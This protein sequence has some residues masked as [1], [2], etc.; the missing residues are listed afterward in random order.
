MREPRGTCFHDRSP[1]TLARGVMNGDPAFGSPDRKRRLAARSLYTEAFH[2]WVKKARE[3]IGSAEVDALA[4]EVETHLQDLQVAE[5]ELRVQTEELEAALA[6]AERQR[7]RYRE[8]F[9]NAPIPYLTTDPAGRILEANL[10]AAA[11]LGLEPDRARGQPLHVFLADGSQL[12]IRILGVTAGRPVQPWESEVISGSGSAIPVEISV[13]SVEPRRGDGLE[14]LWMLHDVRSRRQARTREGE[15]HREQAARAALKQV[16]LRARFLADASGRLMGVLEPTRVWEVAAELAGGHATAALLVESRGEN[17]VCVRGIGGAGG[18]RGRLESLMGRVVE[19]GDGSVEG[20]PLRPIRV[21]LERGEPEIIPSPE[22]PPESAGS[23]LVVPVRSSSRPWGAMVLWLP[24]E[25]RI[26]EE[27]LVADNLADRVALALESATM[28]QEVVRSRRKAEEA[29]TA[30]ADFLSVVS[31]ELR[32]PLTA[33]VSYAELLQ[34]R[35]SELPEKLARYAHQIAAAADHQRQLVEQ[36]LI[37]KQVQRESDRLEPEDLDYRKVARSAVA[38]VQPQVGDRPVDVEFDVPAEPV[39]GVSDR[40]KLQQILTNVLSN[41]IRHTR[42]GHV[43]LTL[44]TERHWV[45][46]RVEDTG[47]G[48]PA[49]SLPRVFDRF[50]RGAGPSGN[51]GG[52][53]L[54]LTIT[55]ELVDGMMGE[56]E[57]ESEV[58]VGTTF[59]VR[60]PRVAVGSKPEGD[61]FAHMD[62]ETGAAR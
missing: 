60:V 28:F 22:A 23:C 12:R 31:H 43:R 14:V 30:E 17:S 37:Y 51:R 40:G 48:I 16:A 52:S 3:R 49:E 61:D 8:L 47:E 21:A 20:L 24:P 39:L 13:R 50:W 35:A 41:G 18:A 10:R 56:I 55:R 33:I 19:L 9:D 29:S 46:F 5:E 1:A 44:E 38:M 15:L 58:G 45:V 32:T 54:G 53:G 25:A 36:I 11:L 27:L 34:D 2:R 26:G 7:R 4:A 42:E 62:P 57:V 59:T 6:E